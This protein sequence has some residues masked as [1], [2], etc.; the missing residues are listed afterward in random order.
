M[1]FQ[2]EEPPI[3]LS[4]GGSLIVPN[5]GID[6]VFLSKLNTFIRG[7]IKKGKR[8][9]VVAGGGRVARQ[10]R[11]AGKSVIGTMTDQDL[12]WLGIHATRLNAHLLRTIFE[13]IAHPR[14]IENYDKKLDNWKEPLVIG[15]G[16]KPGWSTD[17]DAVVLARDYGANLII[18]MSNIDWVYDKDPGKFSD[19]KKIDRLTW[20]ELQELVGTEW[21]PGI[22]TPF[23]PIA[24][25][26]AKELDLTVIVTNGNDFRNL[27]NIIDGEA[28]KGTVVMPYRIDASFYDREYYTGKKAGYKFVTKESWIAVLIYK[29]ADYYRALV[30]KLFINPK[31]VLD[32]GC[33][34][35]HLVR[36]LRKFGIE[37][38]G[39]EI[40]EHALE[41]A[42]PDV[43]PYL[44]LGDITK[45]PYKIDQFDL[46]VTFDVLE[47]VDRAKIKKAINE[48]IRVSRKYVL[49]K[50]YTK[51]N[52]WIRWF[53]SKDFSRLSIFTRK[54]WQRLF[55]ENPKAIL[56]RNTIFRLPAFMES[57]FLLKKK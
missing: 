28:F 35:G 51:E 20:E 27:N 3:V 33:G 13:D 25:Q 54:F 50:I 42:D 43:A 23:D 32:V 45:L 7:Y 14:I 38:H 2:Y 47:H 53:H 55:L 36:A 49:H 29:L 48:T 5:G 37:A 17:Y 9:F 26:L 18:N 8:F 12:D 21:S 6:D 57:I 15:A 22:N 10:Y 16:W 31:N 40:S 34:T 46:V 56:Q 4:I 44:K 1:L 11:D 41:M 24:A 30:I 52:L 39:V 19:A